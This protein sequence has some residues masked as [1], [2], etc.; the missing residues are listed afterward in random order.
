MSIHRTLFIVKPDAVERNLIGRI[1]AHVEERGIPDRRARLA[2]LTREEAEEF[3]AEHRG[4]PFFGELRRLHDLGPGVA[5]LP[6]GRAAVARLREVVGATDPAQAAEGTVRKRFGESKQRNSVHASDSPA[7]A[8]REIKIFFGVAAL[9]RS[10]GCPAGRPPGLD[11]SP[12]PV[13]ECGAL[14]S[15]RPDRI[16]RVSIST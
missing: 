15:Q 4:R 6:R 5:D 12:G 1:L 11:R 9:T 7:S 2:H 10:T 3:Y 16:C 13:L 14:Y 8:E